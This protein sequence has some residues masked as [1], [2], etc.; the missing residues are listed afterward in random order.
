MVSGENPERWRDRPSLLRPVESLVEELPVRDWYPI[1]QPLELEI[2]CGDG[3]FLFHHAAKHRARNF[4]GIERLKGRLSKLDRVA[5]REGLTNL[6]LVRLEARYLMRYLLPEKSFSAIHVYFPD[7][8]PKK[9]HRKNRIVNEEFTE[10]ASRILK[11]GGCVHLRTDDENYHEQMLEVF[12]SLASWTAIE[13]SD[14]LK[15]IRTDFEREFNSKDI[16][17]RYANYELTGRSNVDD[18]AATG[19]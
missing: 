6:A 15:A 9:K 7:P 4:L 16:P 18:R 10:L 1:Q 5:R 13:I 14:D 12:A 2:G 17:T 3:S 19:A 11:E 8:W